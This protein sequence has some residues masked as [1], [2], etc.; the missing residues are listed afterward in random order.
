MAFAGGFSSKEE[1][2]TC[3]CDKHLAHEALPIGLLDT[4]LPRQSIWLTA[5]AHGRRRIVPE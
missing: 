2:R 3:E 1:K 4:N 5:N